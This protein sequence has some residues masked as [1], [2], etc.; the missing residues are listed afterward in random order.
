MLVVRYE[1]NAL[2]FDEKSF[3]STILSFPPYWNYKSH[4][5]YVAEKITTSSTKDK[6]H[7]KSD[8]SD[9]SIQNGLRQPILF[10]FVLDKKRRYKVFSEPETIHYKKTNLF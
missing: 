10:S 6:I 4:N 8:V 2:R 9:G 7:L 1:I 3:F 5:E